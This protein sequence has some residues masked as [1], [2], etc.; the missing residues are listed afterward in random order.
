MSKSW[1]T[2]LRD[3]TALAVVAVYVLPII[4]WGLSA[5]TPSDALLDLHRVLTFDFTPTLS[6]F[7]LTMLGAGGTIFDSRQ[8]LFDSIVIGLMSTAIVL[9]AAL[10]MRL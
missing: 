2:L 6:N 7:S 5:F 4:W 1:I 8:S 3:A 10:P 9:A